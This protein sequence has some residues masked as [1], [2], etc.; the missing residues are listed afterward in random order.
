MDFDTNSS[1]FCS[2]LVTG[3]LFA[4]V[5]PKALP[6]GLSSTI[7][8]TLYHAWHLR[9]SYFIYLFAAWQIATIHWR[10]WWKAP[11]DIIIAAYPTPL[12]R[13]LTALRMIVDS[14]RLLQDAYD[15]VGARQFRIVAIKRLIHLGK[16]EGFCHPNDCPMGCLCIGP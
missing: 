13:W 9:W 3:E 16:W 1:A 4:P 12:G 7:D 15:S 11:S 14:E 6:S 2:K 10:Y 5:A 8:V